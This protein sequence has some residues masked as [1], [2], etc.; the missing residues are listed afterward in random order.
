MIV[1]GAVCA[2]ALA[3]VLDVLLLAAQRLVQPWARAR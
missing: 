3:I 1:A 2:T